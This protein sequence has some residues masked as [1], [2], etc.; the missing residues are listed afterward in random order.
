MITASWKTTVGGI[1]SLIGGA[2]LL[3]PDDAPGAKD[4]KPWAPA[5]AAIGAGL[6]GLA[7]R[8]NNVSSEQAGVVKKDETQVTIKPTSESGGTN[9]VG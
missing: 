2:V 8:D 7:A 6:I 4:I 3:V 9:T 5:M 1:I